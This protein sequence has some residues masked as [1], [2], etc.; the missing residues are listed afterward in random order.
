MDAQAASVNTIRI[1]AQ[2]MGFALDG[3]FIAVIGDDNAD[4]QA[5]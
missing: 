4:P 5:I 2:K 3:L 1:A